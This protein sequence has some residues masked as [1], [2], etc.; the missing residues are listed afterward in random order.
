M[1]ERW[2]WILRQ[3]GPK[4]LVLA[5]VTRTRVTQTKV[6]QTKV[7]QTRVTLIRVTLI[8]VTLNTAIPRIVT[9]IM[10]VRQLHHVGLTLR[11]NRIRIT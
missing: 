8:K 3:R 2:R 5:Q 1:S 10:A 6:T 7:T 9:G 4:L 11:I